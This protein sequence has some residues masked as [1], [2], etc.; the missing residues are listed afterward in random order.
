MT[1]WIK[2]SQRLPPVGKKVLVIEDGVDIDFGTRMFESDDMFFICHSTSYD[3]THWMELPVL[4][5]D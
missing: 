4:P 2:C 5:N 3:V 1:E